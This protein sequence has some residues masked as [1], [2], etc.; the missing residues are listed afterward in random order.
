MAYRVLVQ[1]EDCTGVRSGCWDGGIAWLREQADRP[2]HYDADDDYVTAAVFASTGDA[3]RALDDAECVADWPAAWY[4][5]IVDDDAS[6]R[7]GLPPAHWAR[8]ADDD[9]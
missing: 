7:A 2:G 1:C 8:G 4:G 5:M 6:S 9:D 3:Q